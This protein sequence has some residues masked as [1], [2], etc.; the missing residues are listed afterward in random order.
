MAEHIELHFQEGFSGEAVEVRVAGKAAAHFVARTRVQTGLAHIEKLELADGT[1]V[2]ITMP[3]TGAEASFK[4]SKAS[5]H[6][7]V[8]VVNQKLNVEAKKESPGYL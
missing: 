2:R 5:P 6:I 1:T 8:N 4:V 3:A 7:V